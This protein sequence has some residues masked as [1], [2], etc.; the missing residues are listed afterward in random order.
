[1]TDPFKTERYDGIG[2]RGEEELQ[3][4]IVFVALKENSSLLHE[5]IIVPINLGGIVV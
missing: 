4:Y 2:R 3:H 1:M 5:T